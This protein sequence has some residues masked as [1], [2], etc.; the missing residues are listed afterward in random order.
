MRSL[1][2]AAAAAGPAAALL[3]EFDLVPLGPTASLWPLLVIVLASVFGIILGLW[4]GRQDLRRL[5]WL[6]VTPN[7][8]VLCFYGFLLLFF[9]L[10]GS[11]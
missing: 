11:R 4:I 5:R 6:A 9:G 2:L 10:G 8:L 7:G 3:H 1:L